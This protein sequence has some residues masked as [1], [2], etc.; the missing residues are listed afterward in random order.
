MRNQ[1]LAW[2]GIVLWLVLCA[3]LLGYFAQE[4]LSVF[5]HSSRLYDA[6]QQPGFT[7]ALTVKMTEAFG[8]LDNTILHFSD[9]TCWCQF[10]AQRHIRSV[11]E[12]GVAAG[13]RNIEI[14]KTQLPE[15]L[16]NAIPSFPAVVLFNV[17]GELVY[18][19]PYSSG[20]YCSAG[21]GIVEPYIDSIGSLPEL[22]IPFDAAGCY[23]ASS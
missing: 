15:G 21:N 22:A 16:A 11:F 3:G 1:K 17:K 20:I 5:D 10:V 2:A 4:K 8:P 12:R 14:S 18:L 9:D 19:G 6:V 23:C 7:Q 13:L